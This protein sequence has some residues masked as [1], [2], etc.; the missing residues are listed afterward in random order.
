MQD[1]HMLTTCGI[2]SVSGYSH[3]GS[4][5]VLP[6]TVPAPLIGVSD[7][8]CMGFIDGPPPTQNQLS[9]LESSNEGDRW[10]YHPEP[11]T[12]EQLAQLKA[13][14]ETCLGGL[15]IFNK[16]ASPG[17]GPDNAARTTTYANL[18]HQDERLTE[19]YSHGHRKDLPHLR[20]LAMRHLAA[21]QAVFPEH[22]LHIN[23][24]AYIHR[25]KELCK[26]RQHLHRDL[27][28]GQMGGHL[29]FTTF[30]SIVGCMPRDHPEAGYFVPRSVAGLPIPWKTLPMPAIE[31]HSVTM[32]SCIVEGPIPPD[33]KARGLW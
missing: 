23:F 10:A 11:E 18:P 17:R 29:A 2:W 21:I 6:T 1:A 27:R 33:W 19:A 12:P 30:T 15:E 25:D 14:S 13:E 31:G 20:A 16:D 7:Q 32:H 9:F 24:A 5:L 22:N 26:V 4:R 28:R 8:P 3:P